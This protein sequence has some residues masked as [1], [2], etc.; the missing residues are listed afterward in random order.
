MKSKKITNATSKKLF[1]KYGKYTNS[2]NVNA[3]PTRGG[4]RL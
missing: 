4:F 2:L 1:S 3:T